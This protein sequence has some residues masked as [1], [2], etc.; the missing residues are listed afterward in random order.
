MMKALISLWALSLVLT[1]SSAA[2]L[3]YIADG[4]RGC[5]TAWINANLAASSRVDLCNSAC[6]RVRTSIEARET[7]CKDATTKIESLLALMGN[8]TRNIADEQKL[9]KEVFPDKHEDSCFVDLR[10]KLAWRDFYCTKPA[11]SGSC[12]DLDTQEKQM[13][14]QQDKSEA[15]L[16]AYRRFALENYLPYYHTEKKDG[17][18]TKY[19]CYTSMLTILTQPEAALFP[20]DKCA[21]HPITHKVDED[22]CSS[23]CRDA[24]LAAIMAADMAAGYEGKGCAA[25][26]YDKMTEFTFK[27]GEDVTTTVT[28]EEDCKDK[29]PCTKYSKALKECG[30]SVFE[31]YMPDE[32]HDYLH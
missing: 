11:P 10:D 19:F 6:D 14:C 28:P 13:E 5:N 12:S 17:D 22:T 26:Y 3:N 7:P 25:L 31:D 32:T 1:G 20:R 15:Q 27:N 4:G 8:T 18:T 9:L 24:T 23:G 21:A 30:K 29:W 2:S 16:T